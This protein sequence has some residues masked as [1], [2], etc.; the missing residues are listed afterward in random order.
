MR[1]FVV[2]GETS[3]DTHAAALLA[4]LQ[5]LRPDL[6]ISG[7]GGPKLLLT[8]PRRVPLQGPNTG[9]D[10]VSALL[11]VHKKGSLQDG[12]TWVLRLRPTTRYGLRWQSP[13]CQGDSGGQAV[14]MD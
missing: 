7:L 4:E 9:E 14:R 11:R 3:G 2:A 10:L 6:Q 1:I 5:S 12:F 13:Q 8:Q